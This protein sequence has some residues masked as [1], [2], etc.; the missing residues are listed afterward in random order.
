MYVQD[1]IAAISTPLGEGGIGVIRVSGPGA[2]PIAATIFRKKRDGGLLSHRF[3]YGEVV[4][5]GSGDTLDEAL[6]VMMRAPRSYTREDLVEIQCH[7][8]YLVVQRLLDLVLRQGA[9]LAEPGE[10]T[11]RAF[12]NGRIDLVQAEAVI[13]VIRSKTDAA[14]TLAQHQRGGLLSERIAAVRER[15]VHALALVE[16][17]IDFPEEEVG[18]LTTA[19][20]GRLAGEAA[21]GIENLLAGFSE[22]KVLREG[23]SVL[24]AGK[25]NVGKS[26]LL[27]T[28]L[29]EKRAI[30]TSVPGTTRDIIEEVVNIGGLPVRMLDTAGVRETDD[31]VEQEG[32]RLTLERIPQA[33]LVLFMVDGSRPFDSEDR[34]I[35][36]ALGPA[37]V[38][39][40]QNKSDLPAA[41]ELPVELAETEKVAISTLTGAGIE[42]LRAM[43]R[44]A[45]LHGRAVD[46]REFVALSRARHRDALVKAQGFVARFGDSLA[47][48]VGL[49]LLAWELREALQAVG[50][51]TGE[52]TPDEVLDLIFSRFCIGK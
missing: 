13:D 29:R 21:T 51:V 18:S 27:N 52:T 32:V 31:I 24:I 6:L 45:F 12:L 49:E 14:L 48:G 26:S 15:L 17:H 4:D 1:T 38:I 47:A 30:V 34:M 41:I 16:A 22:G 20:I 9:R 25:P 36:A 3:Y 23:V 40:V 28:L 33:D 19:E 42:R 2:G 10:F 46:G 11:K 43:I 8:G 5:P 44:D 50:E 35:M 37:R 7:G 39:M